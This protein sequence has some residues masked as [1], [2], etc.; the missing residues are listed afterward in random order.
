M[1]PRMGKT[2]SFSPTTGNCGKA[3]ESF[4]LRR[5]KRKKKGACMKAAV[6]LSVMGGRSR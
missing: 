2:Y 3:K 1:M 6:M 5:R 4:S